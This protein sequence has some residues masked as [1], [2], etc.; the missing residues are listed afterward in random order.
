MR[1]TDIDALEFHLNTGVDP[2]AAEA[3]G[4][5]LFADLMRRTPKN[6]MNLNED[7]LRSVG[8]AAEVMSD[9][10]MS[11]DAV[12]AIKCVMGATVLRERQAALDKI[13]GN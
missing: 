13:L 5:E 1:E 9:P 11:I 10:G 8:Y 3:A 6:P 7:Q 2:I 12:H 4:E